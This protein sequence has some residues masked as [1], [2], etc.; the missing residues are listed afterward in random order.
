MIMISCRFTRMVMFFFVSGPDF[1]NLQIS[2]VVWYDK[3]TPYGE[4]LYQWHA[5]S[6]NP[7]IHLPLTEIVRV[8]D[9]LNRCNSNE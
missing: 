6:G 5:V 1:I 3:N 9:I 4:T 2:P 7:I 8:I